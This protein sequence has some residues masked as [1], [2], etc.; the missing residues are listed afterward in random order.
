MIEKRLFV[1]IL[2]LFVGLGA[3]Y[4][5]VT[6]AFEASDELWHYPM[7]QHLGNGHPLPVQVF[8]PAQAGPWKQEA[9]QPPLYYYMGAVLT[10]W[11]DTSD[12][13]Q[14]R[15]LNPHVDNGVITV[16]GNNNLAIH[17]TAFD[18]WQGSLLAIRIVRLFSVLLGAVTVYFTFRVAQMAFPQRPEIVLGTTAVV[19]FTPMFLFISG[20][21]NN[22]N[23]IIPLAALALWLMIRVVVEK[24]TQQRT[25]TARDWLLLGVVI[26]LAALTKISGIGLLALA[27]GTIFISTWQGSDRQIRWQRL[28]QWGVVATGR[29]LL[30]LV[31]VLLI[32]GWWYYRNVTLYGD[33]K[34]WNAFIA[35]LGQRA[36]PASLAQLWGERRGFMMAYW[37]LFGGVNIPMWGW[38]YRFLNGVVVVGGIGFVIYLVQEMRGWRPVWSDALATSNE[39]MSPLLARLYT[40]VAAVLALVERY[41]PLVVSLLWAVAI[42]Y[43][44]ISWATTTWSSQ[45][46]LVFSALPA[47]SL[48][49]LVGLVG[50]LPRLWAGLVSG[51]LA[52][53]MFVLAVAAP[54]VWIA[55][56]YDAEMPLLPFI[57]TSESYTFG[58]TMRLT[59]FEISSG[60]RGLG[61]ETAVLPGD[62]IDVL[63]SWEVLQPIEQDWSVFVHVIDPVLGTPI[64]QRDMYPRRGLQ[65]TSLLQP[66]QRFSDSYRLTIPETAVAPTQLALS[67]GLY[68]FYTWERLPLADGQDAATLATLSLAAKPGQVPN[69]LAVN[70]EDTFQLMGY[71]LQ[72]RRAA[73]GEM[74]VL[75]LYWQVERPLADDYTFF[76]QIVS[77][78]TT[79]WASHDL[80][81]MPL[82][83]AW[84]TGETQT[85]TFSLPLRED[86]PT[87]VYP[88]IVGMYTRTEEGGF[89]RLQILTA[90]G[91]LT[92]DFF[93]VTPIRVE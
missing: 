49:L 89:D 37:G 71:E 55:P 72:P 66:G 21:V 22:D 52:G 13:E 88:I 50:W 24:R 40:F 44:L 69:R 74:V 78:D 92:D 23:L 70:F 6:P 4:A 64:A 12:M 81:P 91:R 25:A 57:Q 26:G 18:P 45:G 15:W 75:Q 79:R 7:I 58:E 8:D 77:E 62:T 48:L 42:V 54:W 82:T 51:S 38:I 10:F 32:A 28:L 93:T 1:L 14:V 43:G 56:A 85:L 61:G 17:D 19:A 84:V 86:T 9:S 41:F 46:R 35:V 73:A 34:G 65:P 68:D 5:L 83:S 29:W 90:D 33:W 39:E 16:D 76:A 47:L 3:T 60:K 87:D 11:I 27:W 67:V 31:P 2:V 30:V 36:H 63:L 80:S 59:G 20:A 53:F